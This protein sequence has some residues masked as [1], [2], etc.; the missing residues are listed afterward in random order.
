MLFLLELEVEL[1]L[2]GVQ[3]CLTF[4]RKTFHLFV[5]CYLLENAFLICLLHEASQTPFFSSN[6]AFQLLAVLCKFCMIHQ[7][8]LIFVL[9]LAISQLLILPLFGKL[10]S[11][12]SL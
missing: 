1:I 8:P 6:A 12:L 9:H 10:C 5:V 11:N 2:V 7:Q 4:W 3:R